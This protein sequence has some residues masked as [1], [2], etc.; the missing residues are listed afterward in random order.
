[1]KLKLP[2][3]EIKY[4]SDRYQSDDLIAIKIGKR[5]RKRG[6]FSKKDFLEICEWKNPR[7]KSRCEL[8]DESFIKEVTQ[9][10]LSTKDEWLKIEVLIILSGVGWPTASGILHFSTNYKY[11]IV[12]HRA[13]WSIDIETEIKSIDKWVEYTEFCRKIASEANVNLRTLDRALWQY[14]KENQ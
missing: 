12:N 7:S 1:M 9:I 4:W 5:S 3:S 8:N 2:I 10:A 11:P 14:S 13:L 6:Y